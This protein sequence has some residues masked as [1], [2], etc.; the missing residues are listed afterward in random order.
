MKPERVR[1]MDKVLVR[2]LLNY[3]RFLLHINTDGI[4][5]HKIFVRVTTLHTM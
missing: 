2:N 3:R 1:S 5:Q 4:K